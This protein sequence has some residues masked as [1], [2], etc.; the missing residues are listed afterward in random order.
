MKK[1]QQDKRRRPARSSQ[2]W[3]RLVSE[4]QTSNQSAQEF[5]D[6]RGLGAHNLRKWARRLA[7]PAPQTSVRKT[8]GKPEP[9][10]IPIGPAADA[11]Q[12]TPTAVGCGSIEVESPDGIVV[13]LF[14]DVSTEV[15]NATL[16]AL[17]RRRSC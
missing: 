16:S 4:W 7:K 11:R 8:H 5:A 3:S 12:K 6:S 2:E 1:Q 13:R 10:L 15:L 17:S 14:G 9:R